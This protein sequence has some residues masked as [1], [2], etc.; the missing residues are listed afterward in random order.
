VWRRAGTLYVAHIVTSV[1]A[2][3]IIAFG[4]VYLNSTKLVPSV[5]FAIMLEKPLEAIIGLPAL[6]YQIGYFNILPLYFT[7]LIVSPLYILIGLRS[8]TALVAF[9]TAIWILAGTFRLNLPNYPITGGWFFNPISWQLIYA[10]GVAAGL[11]IIEKRKL[12]SFNPWLFGLSVTYLVFAMVWI[13]ME[14]GALP[15]D[16]YFPFFLAGFDKTF[17]ALP[18]L[19]HVLA[20]AYVLT[21]LGAVSRLIATSAFKP[22]E[23]IGQHS[24]AVFATG[25]VLSIALQVYRASFHTGILED[26]TLILGGILIQYGLAR[27]LAATSE[28]KRGKPADAAKAGEPALAGPMIE[29]P[30]RS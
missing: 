20:L 11:A 24:L 4:I 15:L 6:G 13:Q 21:N 10:I 12:V 27:F 17:L 1:I 14:M 2:I 19:L 18:R 7:L 29:Q 8:R 3:A 28:K 30:L 23:L 22:I 16:R 26:G 5:N 25:S 9:A